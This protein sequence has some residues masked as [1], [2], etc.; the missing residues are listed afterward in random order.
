MKPTVEISESRYKE[1]LAAE[2]KLDALEGHGV[3]NWEG[4]DDAMAQFWENEEEEED[5]EDS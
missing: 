2:A 5:E 4:Y 1:L 3:D